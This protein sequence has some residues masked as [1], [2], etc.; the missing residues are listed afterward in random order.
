MP[1]VKFTAET[2][3]EMNAP[4]DSGQLEYHWDT[5][6]SGFGLRCAANTTRRS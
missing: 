1:A 2:L 6:V 3:K 5:V 4:T